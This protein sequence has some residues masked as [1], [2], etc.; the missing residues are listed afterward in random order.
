MS[1]MLNKTSWSRQKNAASGFHWD[2]IKGGLDIKLNY[3][4]FSETC[5]SQAE[6]ESSESKC[7]KGEEW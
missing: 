4:V 1:T 6:K 5:Y 3:L 7:L 2:V